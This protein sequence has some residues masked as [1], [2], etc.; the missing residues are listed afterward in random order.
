MPSPYRVRAADQTLH[1]QLVSLA[2]QSPFT[3]AFGNHIFSGPVH[4]ERGW[5]R[6]AYRADRPDVVVG[7]TCF[8][9]KIRSA[10]TKLY[11]L[12]VARDRRGCGVG[13]LLMNDLEGVS[14]SGT[15]A[16]D[17]VKTNPACDFYARLGYT[18][19]GEALGGKAYRME[20]RRAE[21]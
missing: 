15:V 4:Y 17:C 20:K 7:L 5:I 12:I 2:R 8:R 14:P 3:N 13:R 16:L 21:G 6:V 9:H 18:V 10:E 11:F 1:P 19:V